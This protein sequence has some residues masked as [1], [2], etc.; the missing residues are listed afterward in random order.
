[1]ALHS[2][3]TGFPRSLFRCAVPFI[4]PTSGSMGNNGALTLSVALPVAVVNGYIYLPL[5]AI[6]A[7]SAAGWYYATFSSTTVGTVFNNVYTPATD[8]LPVVP[9][10]PT[11]FVT[12]GPGAFT[13]VVTSQDGPT[14][15][16]PAGTMG[17]NGTLAFQSVIR[18]TTDA[19]NKTSIFRFGSTTIAASV[20]YNAV[21]GGMATVR[22]FG[23]G[24]TNRQTVGSIAP[25]AAVSS[26]ATVRTFDMATA[27]VVNINLTNDAAATD[28]QVLLFMEVTQE[29]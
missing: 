13:A 19:T 23:A 21:L 11:A 9:S 5:N 26:F 17:P 18:T 15:T 27:L 16:L 14:F 22:L 7:G 25:T 12:T 24:A 3:A 20:A 2:S 1:M 4:M 8:G 10:S 28:H 6:V 29:A